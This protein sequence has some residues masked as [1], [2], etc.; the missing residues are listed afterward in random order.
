ME[1]ILRWIDNTEQWILGLP[2]GLQVPLVL[3]VLAVIAMLVVRVLTVLIDLVG[4]RLHSARTS[5]D[6]EDSARHAG[7][8]GTR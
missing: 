1:A 5:A 4:D 6:T 7:D 8:E 2:Y 3:I